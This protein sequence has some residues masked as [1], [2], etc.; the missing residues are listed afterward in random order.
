MTINDSAA[1]IRTLIENHIL[2][3]L[4]T[5]STN[6]YNTGFTMNGTGDSLVITDAGTRYAVAVGS[7]LDTASLSNR[8]DVNLQAIIDSTTNVRGELQSSEHLLRTISLRT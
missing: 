7:I 5:D 3:D 8:I 6:E 1:V 2:A 4:D